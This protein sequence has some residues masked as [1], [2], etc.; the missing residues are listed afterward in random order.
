MTHDER[1][2]EQMIIVRVDSDLLQD[3][4]D[5]YVPPRVR[6]AAEYDGTYIM[7]RNPGSESTERG[8]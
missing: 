7:Y 6:V 1:S 3:L 2:S 8:A 4:I 5:L